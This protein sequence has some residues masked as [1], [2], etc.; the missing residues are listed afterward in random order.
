MTQNNGNNESQEQHNDAQF[1]DISTATSPEALAEIKRCRAIGLLDSD[2]L[3]YRRF[4]GA[5][6]QV[7]INQSSAVK[8]AQSAPI[9]G[10]E[11][12]TR[13]HNLGV[14]LT[15]DDELAIVGSNPDTG[16]N[17]WEYFTEVFGIR[18]IMTLGMLR[19]MRKD[20]ERK[21]G[22]RDGLGQKKFRKY[23]DAEVEQLGMRYGWETKLNSEALNEDIHALAVILNSFSI[24]DCNVEGLAEL[25]EILHASPNLLKSWFNNNITV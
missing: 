7:L 3:L 24:G 6:E 9:G 12:V 16:V 23:M 21:P 11:A 10:Y 20:A 25:E 14:P 22:V 5:P 8:M 18:Q 1:R 17:G 4:P 2:M 15:L 13:L 19:K